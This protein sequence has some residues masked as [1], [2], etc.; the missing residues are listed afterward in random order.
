MILFLIQLN[1]CHTFV[2]NWETDPALANALCYAKE[3]GVQILAYDTIVNEKELIL[4]KKIP[5]YL[6]QDK[7]PF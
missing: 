3:Q 1:G 2:P 6:S 7:F 5:V 4:N